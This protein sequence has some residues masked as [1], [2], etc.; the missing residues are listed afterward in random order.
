MNG[1]AEEGLGEYKGLQVLPSE[2]WVPFRRWN[3]A[4]CEHFLSGRYQGRPIYLDLDDRAFESIRAQAFP[5]VTNAPSHLITSVRAT[6][7]TAIQTSNIFA[8]HVANC[9]GWQKSHYAGFP[10]FV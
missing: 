5:E 6:L 7:S 2:R 1:N 9:S 10:P 4:L 8:A 3:Q